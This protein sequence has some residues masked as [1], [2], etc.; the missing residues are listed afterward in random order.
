[1]NTKLTLRLDR[2][3]IGRAKME[4]E[5][6]GKSVSQMVAEFF[7]SLGATSAT[8]RRYPPL[9]ASLLG[10]LRDKAVSKGDYQR[11]LREKYL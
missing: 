6:R 10:C 9:T 4:A 8:P 3:L 5:Q 11:H 2:Q 1:M 7:N